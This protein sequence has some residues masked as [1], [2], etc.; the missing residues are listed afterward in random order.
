M[1]V[2]LIL[3]PLAFCR[4]KLPLSLP[5]HLPMLL[6][7]IIICLPPAE[8]FTPSAGGMNL[9]TTSE[10]IVTTSNSAQP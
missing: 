10:A 4:T 2:I 8:K 1:L 5:P 9:T 3:P 7:L 6:A